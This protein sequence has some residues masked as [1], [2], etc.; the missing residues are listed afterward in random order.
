[1][2]K[3]IVIV[4]GGKA[5]GKNLSIRKI[6]FH[7]I[8]GVSGGQTSEGVKIKVILR[9][10]VLLHTPAD[11][12]AASS[13]DILTK[14]LFLKTEYEGRR[15]AKVS[16]YEIPP[17]I[18]QGALGCISLLICTDTQCFFWRTDRGIEFRNND[19]SEGL[20]LHLQLYGCRGL[21]NA[22]IS[23]RL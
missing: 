12:E 14:G 22:N 18:S 15:R 6:H 4:C 3:E 17:Q 10:G 21:E 19:L 20:H 8:A 5:F 13:R 11:F 9:V 7:N 1:M 23:H 2:K 16:V